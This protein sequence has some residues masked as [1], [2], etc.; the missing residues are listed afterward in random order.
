MIAVRLR[1]SG[2]QTTEQ[3]R[4]RRAEVITRIKARMAE[5]GEMYKP[6]DAYMW[7]HEGRGWIVRASSVRQLQEALKMGD[8][9]RTQFVQAVGYMLY[10]EGSLA[11]THIDVDR[12]FKLLVT[13]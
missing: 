5:C 1:P 8:E 12:Y 11:R 13:D 6:E 4:E 3:R 9:T 10:A 7:H 2:V